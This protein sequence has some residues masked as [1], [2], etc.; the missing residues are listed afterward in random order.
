MSGIP[1]ALQVVPLVVA[2]AALWEARRAHNTAKEALGA[3]EAAED[4]VAPWAPHP[5]PPR[6]GHPS[7]QVDRLI[8]DILDWGDKDSEEDDDPI[9]WDDDDEET[10]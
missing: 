8:K 7:A 2:A 1:V 9:G 10:P 4:S 5:A 3:A 6:V